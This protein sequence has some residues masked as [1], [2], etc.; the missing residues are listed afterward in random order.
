MK[1]KEELNALKNDVEALNRKLAELTE[2]EMEHV[3][4]GQGLDPHFIWD[5]EA[6]DAMDAAPPAADIVSELKS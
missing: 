4:G 5:H 6:N 2:N 1:T 3:T